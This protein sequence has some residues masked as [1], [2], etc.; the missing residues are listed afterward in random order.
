MPEAL[1]STIC[2]LDVKSQSV[3]DRND[4]DPRTVCGNKT[5]KSLK[6]LHC[7]SLRPD[8]G[9]YFKAQHEV[10]GESAST[11][12]AIEEDGSGFAYYPSGR[13]ALCVAQSQKSRRFNCMFFEDGPSSRWL[14]SINEWGIG[15]VESAP[16]TLSGEE[17]ALKIFLTTRDYVQVSSSGGSSSSSSSN[18]SSFAGPNA[19]TDQVDGMNMN[20]SSSPSAKLTGKSTGGAVERV[21]WSKATDD[22]SFEKIYMPVV[23][24]RT[25]PPVVS[26]RV[27]Y[28][29][30][31]KHLAP[32]NSMRGP[33]RTGILG[34]QPQ[35][36]GIILVDFRCEKVK[37][38]FVVG[39]VPPA[40]FDKSHPGLALLQIRTMA[41]SDPAQHAEDVKLESAPILERTA[42]ALESVQASI[43][44]RFPSPDK[45]RRSI[46]NVREFAKDATTGKTL[47]GTIKDKFNVSGAGPSASNSSTIDN[48]TQKLTKGRIDYNVE[49]E[50]AQKVAK[51]N[52][53]I[54]RL[55]G[56]LTNEVTG[57]SSKIGIKYLS[58]R[59][60]LGG[61][62]KLKASKGIDEGVNRWFFPKTVRIL[63]HDEFETAVMT[64]KAR[65]FVVCFHAP[66]D[67]QT[68]HA[69]KLMQVSHACA[70]KF[71]KNMDFAMVDMAERGALISDKKFVNELAH[72][73][74]VTST[75]WLLI[76]SRGALM[77]SKKMTGFVE[78]LRFETF[79]KP[80]ALIVEL[81]GTVV[82]ERGFPDGPENQRK[83]KNALVRAQ[84]DADLALS[85]KDAM[86]MAGRM[87]PPYGMV[88]ATSEI[89][90]ADLE[91][92]RSMVRRRNSS[93]L[94]FLVHHDKKHQICPETQARL[95]DNAPNGAVDFVFRRPLSTSRV[96]SVLAELT[97]T[98]FHL[99]GE[100]GHQF[101]DYLKN[102]YELKT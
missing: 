15:K 86:L 92:I 70:R 40:L 62:S 78:R 77:L 57:E 19:P 64:S 63:T 91:G 95:L 82:G 90:Y 3:L 46:S 22:H 38:T 52:P 5:T 72:K 45:S 97:H 4:T 87:V 83:S 74:S 99:A 51:M 41:R 58:G 96:Q 20:L 9:T 43:E 11:A 17:A 66:W 33:G 36:N 12:L 21:W 42:K 101:W 2:K 23:A 71:E 32:E 79:A 81:T 93:A 80:R 1:S 55:A 94:F 31:A 30:F 65:M 61:E 50:L 67:P 44:E 24:S 75:P 56:T 47:F 98:Q 76:F 49:L 89:P 54:S 8:L 27:C 85:G 100:S 7:R 25:G 88:F 16:K 28:N 26:I 14:G 39:I 73:Y 68:K 34:N 10:Y 69:E 13:R 53:T 37:H 60:M 18:R 35:T 6:H 84:V 102:L 59:L 29:R 48:L